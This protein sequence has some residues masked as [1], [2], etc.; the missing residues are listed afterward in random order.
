MYRPCMKRPAS[1]SSPVM[2]YRGLESCGV[3]LRGFSQ[4]T[5]RQPSVYLIDERRSH[6]TSHADE[7]VLYDWAVIESG[8]IG[9]WFFSQPD[10]RLG[11]VVEEQVIDDTLRVRLAFRDESVSDWLP[12][13]ALVLVCVETPDQELAST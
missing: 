5:A 4:D 13:T 10:D 7:I 11:E 9:A 6:P 12:L 2:V 3:W 1:N 8:L